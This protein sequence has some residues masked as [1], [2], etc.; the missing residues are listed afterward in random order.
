[1]WLQKGL[2]NDF[3]TAGS[4]AGNDE[5]EEKEKQDSDDDSE[6]F[7][8]RKRGRLTGSE[9]QKEWKH[10]GRGKKSKQ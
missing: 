8:P 5:E 6:D 1:M 9:K 10:L 4:S 3:S 2:W 7:L